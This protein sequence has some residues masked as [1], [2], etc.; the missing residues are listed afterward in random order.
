MGFGSECLSQLSFP[1]LPLGRPCVKAV[2]IVVDTDSGSKGAGEVTGMILGS[3]TRSKEAVEKTEAG[4]LSG[5]TA[6]VP[7]AG[8]RRHPNPAQNCSL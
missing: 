1:P 3:L 6:G 7:M 5:S 4:Q 2:L 8:L